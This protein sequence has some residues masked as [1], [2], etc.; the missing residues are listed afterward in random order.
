MTVSLFG[1]TSFC[2]ELE[3]AW[4]VGEGLIEL[5]DFQIESLLEIT[6]LD[7]LLLCNPLFVI[8]QNLIPCRLAEILFQRFEAHVIGDASSIAQ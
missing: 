8:G 7:G 3:P 4:V 1:S 6:H 5:E 2:L